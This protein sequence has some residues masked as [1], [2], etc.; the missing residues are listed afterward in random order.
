M[1]R[2]VIIS[3]NR[4]LRDQAQK[5]MDGVGGLSLIRSI[6]RYPSAVELSRFMRAQG[7]NVVFLSVESVKQALA[8]HAE[9]EAA[10]PGIQ[11]VAIERTCDPQVLLEVMRAG[12]REFLTP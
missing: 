12:I 1:L 9:L 11:V 8:T 7:P 2:G 6:D 5:A 4:E 3:P 10:A